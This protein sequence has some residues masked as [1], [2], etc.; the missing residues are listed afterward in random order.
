MPGEDSTQ[1][2][3][4]RIVLYAIAIAGILA[5]GRVAFP[6]A[7][8]DR[9]LV[10]HG[11]YRL[12]T[13][14]QGLRRPLG[15]ADV[16]GINRPRLVDASDDISQI[17]TLDPA[18]PEHYRLCNHGLNERQCLQAADENKLVL[19]PSSD[20]PRQRWHVVPVDD[21]LNFWRVSS[22]W[23]GEGFSLDIE[24]AGDRNEPV[25]AES[26]NFTGQSWKFTRVP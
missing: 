10:P 2:L 26:G 19:A 12:S 15:L 6:P 22:A 14:W 21:G 5:F 1:P 16:E 23:K 7:R 3:T 13:E 25:L 17:W 24:N 18:G 8:D 4:I 20:S 9:P 11:Q